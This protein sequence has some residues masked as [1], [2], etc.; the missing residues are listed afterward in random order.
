MPPA[1][2]EFLHDRL[3]RGATIILESGAGFLDER[4]EEFQRHRAL[5][6]QAFG[7]RIGRPASL[8]PGHGVPYVEYSWPRAALIRDFSRVVPVAS[9]SGEVIATANG[10][11]VALERRWERGTLIF[12]GAPLGPALLFGDAEARQWFSHCLETQPP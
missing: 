7:I 9:Q 11:S 2:V 3:R 5:L 1:T 10:L 4:G 12:L 8:W 6:D